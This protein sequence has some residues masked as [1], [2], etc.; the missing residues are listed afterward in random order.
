LP[1][2]LVN[3]SMGPKGLAYFAAVETGAGMMFSGVETVFVGDEIGTRPVIEILLFMRG[4]R[5]FFKLN[6]A[7]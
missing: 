3:A 5:G 6:P 2:E 7:C 1:D 4:G